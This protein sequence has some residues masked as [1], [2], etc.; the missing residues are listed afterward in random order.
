MF[1]GLSC[2][3]CRTTI[4]RD[5]LPLVDQLADQYAG[6]TDRV[7]LVDLAHADSHD[8]RAYFITLSPALSGAFGR[9]DPAATPVMVTPVWAAVDRAQ[10]YVARNLGS[11][12]AWR[13]DLLATFPL[14]AA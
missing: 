5:V 8:L 4:Q 12:D 3:S 14:E 9:T 7:R 6:V 10:P 13:A 2:S 1:Y 11:F